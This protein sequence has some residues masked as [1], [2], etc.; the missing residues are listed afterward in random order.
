MPDRPVLKMN[1]R[2]PQATAKVHEII[3]QTT[4]D[5]FELDIKPQAV[6]NSPVT[7][8]GLL[9]N[10]LLHRKHPAGTGNNRRSIDVETVETEH[11]PKSRLFTQ[12]GYGGYLEVGTSRMSAQ[13]YLWPA[14]QQNIDKIPKQIAAKI[15]TQPPAEKLPE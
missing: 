14:F 3:M 2:I 1:L 11:G 10:E 9:R 6:E 5:V 8:E 7:A 13:P 15:Q 12:S 4:Q